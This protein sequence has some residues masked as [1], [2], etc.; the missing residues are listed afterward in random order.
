MRVP[1]FPRLV[2]S[3]CLTLVVF[4]SFTATG[5]ETQDIVEAL[6]APQS[7]LE[8]VARPLRD[9]SSALKLTYGGQAG[10]QYHTNIYRERGNEVD[11]AVA[12]VSPGFRIRSDMDEA[13]INVKGVVEAG[14][15]LT[16]ES[17]DY[18][19][20]DLQ[21]D[22][23]YQLAP[24]S[25]VDIYGEWQFDHVDVGGFAT[26]FSDILRRAEEPT[27]YAYGTVGTRY[28]TPLT[29]DFMTRVGA[30]VLYYNYNN[31]DSLSNRRIIQDD[32]DRHEL[33]GTGLLG[34]HAQPNLLPFVAVDVNTRHYDKQVDATALYE[35]DS[36]GGGVFVGAEYNKQETDDIW[37]TA[38][39]GML[40]QGYDN[41][42][43]PDV[44]TL[45]FDAE[46]DYRLNETT[47]LHGATY[48]KVLENTLF[49]ASSAVQTDVAATLYHDLA[50]AWQ[51][52]GGLRY[53]N[54]DFQI[55]DSGVTPER[56]DEIYQATAGVTYDIADP[57]Y[58][59]G[60]YGYAKRDSNEVRAQYTDNSV[61]FSVGMRY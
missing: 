8:Q 12:F 43:L 32:R 21:V 26:D 60:Q 36:S 54:N 49:G 57:L 9:P 13:T 45:G 20:A 38:R 18:L 4:T 40:H 41:G 28:E 59:R 27:T 58:L 30:S 35:R 56:T 55:N 33:M 46:G 10:L 3:T 52:D 31:V 29:E 16:E 37:A 17:N 11:D 42:F 24:A 2:C 44:N 47:R 7:E 23:R 50:A 25:Y 53:T 48:R 5:A 34:Y 6:D 51:V 39:V 19:D 14:H 15:F 61:L 22:T 1:F